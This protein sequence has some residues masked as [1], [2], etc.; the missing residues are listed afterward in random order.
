MEKQKYEIVL[1][2]IEAGGQTMESLMELIE[3]KSAR[4]VSN[5]FK[6]INVLKKFPVADE[7]GIYRI[8]GEAEYDELTKSSAKAKEAEKKWT[9][10]PQSKRATL[11][12]RLASKISKMN[13]AK[14]KFDADPSSAVL[15]LRNTI[16]VCEFH[17]ANIAR[18]E[19]ETSICTEL[20]L[21][22]EQY[23]ECEDLNPVQ[24]EAQA[25]YTSNVAVEE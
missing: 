20:G 4:G 9:K 12:S 14:A 13:A 6:F 11:E 2:A 5:Q 21:S 17:L 22:L 19:F 15:K 7:G 1:E 18:T 25:K 10:D 8:V 24:E 23:K 3:S 16:A